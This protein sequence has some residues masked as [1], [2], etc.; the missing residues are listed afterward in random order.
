[1]TETALP[2]RRLHRRICLLLAAL[3]TVVYFRVVFW[4]FIPID[5]PMY[6]QEHPRLWGGLT[7]ENVGWAFTTKHFFNWHPLTWL[8][9]MLDC[10]VAGPRAGWLHF[11][12]L[13]LHIADSV[14]LYLVLERM[15]RSYRS[16]AFVALMFALHPLHVESVAWISERKDVLSTLFWIL[17]MG[18]YTSYART[19]SLGRYLLVALWLALGLM[20]KAM[21][22]TLPCVLL[23][24]DYWPL[25]RFQR[26][27]ESGRSKLQAALRLCAEKIPLL[28]LSAFAAHMTTVAQA[29]GGAVRDLETF[30]LTTRVLNSSI[31]YVGYLGKTFWPAAL[32]AY[33]PHPAYSPPDYRPT[34]SFYHLGYASIAVLLIASVLFL[35]FGRNK[36]Y[37]T[38]GWLWYVGTLVPVIGLVQVGSQGMADRYTYVPLIGIFIIIAWG[39]PDLL[40]RLPVPARRFCLDVGSVV[41]VALCLI[42]TWM[43]VGYWKNGIT[44][45][46]HTVAVTH[47]NVR[48]QS[49]LALSHLRAGDAATAATMYETVLKLDP[50]NSQYLNHYSVALMR[51]KRL[52][53]ALLRVRESIALDPSSVSTQLNYAVILME[54]QRHEEAAE[55]FRVALTI[56]PTIAK[57]HNALGISLAKMQR[58]DEAAE[59]YNQALK[60][61]PWQQ[62]AQRNLEL[63]LAK[64]P[65]PE[66]KPAKAAADR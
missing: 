10:Q 62:G 23:L 8:S 31:A 41:C 17:C 36:K 19:P 54:L 43:Q 4:D 35:W 20:S 45:Y 21:L 52:D 51:T 16:A 63:A 50:H 33:Y 47:D 48:A 3:T 28:G 58:Y 25:D 39:V 29:T 55:Q 56:D 57:A 27:I 30:S 60:L 37:L 26:S 2:D 9:Y 24:L 40:S 12:N 15:T 34:E 44:L 32:G 61:N 14:L 46:E 6:V 13:A 42:L 1:M 18:A 53:E 22:V 49:T 5:D 11:V 59:H 65:F 66:E 64:R 38:V 7:L